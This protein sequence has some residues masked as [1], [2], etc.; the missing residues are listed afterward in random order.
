MSSSPSPHPSLGRR[1]VPLSEVAEIFSIS[2]SQ[3]YALVRTGELRAIQIGGRR[4]WRVE[5]S[6]IEGSSQMRV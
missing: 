6:E 3:A 1:F 4:Q 2:P 5:L